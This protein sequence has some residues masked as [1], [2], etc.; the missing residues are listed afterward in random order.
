[1]FLLKILSRLLLSLLYRF[2]DLLFLT[3]YHLIH[4]RRNTARRN[5]RKSFPEKSEGELQEIEEKFYRNLCD[6]AVETKDDIT[7]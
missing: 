6:Y 4:Y 3:I 2:S 5:L 1:M 7:I